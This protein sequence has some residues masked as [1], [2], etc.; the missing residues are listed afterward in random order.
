MTAL[1]RQ[2]EMRGKLL[3]EKFSALRSNDVKAQMFFEIKVMV[4]ALSLK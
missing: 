3:A 2:A 4:S 1:L